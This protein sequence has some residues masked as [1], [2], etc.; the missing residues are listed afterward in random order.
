MRTKLDIDK[1]VLQAVK[2]LAAYERTT[3]GRVISDLAKRGLKQPTKPGVREKVRHGIRMLPNRDDNRD[4]IITN[5]DIDKFR[6]E[7]GI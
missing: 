6:N 5:A 7:D 1:D 3:A 2:E 4:E